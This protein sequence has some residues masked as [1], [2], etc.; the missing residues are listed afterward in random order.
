MISFSSI[1]LITIRELA[2]KN[3][4]ISGFKLPEEGNQIKRLSFSNC[5]FDTDNY[6]K[7]ASI[8]SHYEYLKFEFIEKKYLEKINLLDA[9]T[10]CFRNCELSKEMFSKLNSGVKYLDL[11]TIKL[12]QEDIEYIK[13]NNPSLSVLTN[14][15]MPNNFKINPPFKQIEIPTQTQT[16]NGSE[17]KALVYKN[18][19][20]NVPKDAFL[21]SSGEPYTGNVK[22]EVVEYFTPE[23]ILFSGIPMTYNEGDENFIF[24][25]GGMIDVKGL[26]ESGEP[27]KLAKPIN[28][29]INSSSANT[30]MNLY[31]LNKKG[32]W[33]FKEKDTIIEAFKLNKKKLDSV[34]SQDFK[35]I[36][37]EN[38]VFR[39]PRVLPKIEKIKDS[40][41]FKIKFDELPTTNR[42]I[43]GN[44][45]IYVPYDIDDVTF[46]SKSRL[47]YYGDSAKYYSKLIKSIRK[48]CKKD[49]KKLKNKLTNDYS[50]N[51]PEYIRNIKLE[52]DLEKDVFMLSFTFKDDTIKLPM[53]IDGNR[54][55]IKSELRYNKRLYAKYKKA[56]KKRERGKKKALS[57]VGRL[58]AYKA[59]RLKAIELEREEKRRILR[60]DNDSLMMRPVEPSSIIRVF[61]IDGFGLFNCDAMAR[62]IS[63]E[64]VGSRFICEEKIIDK[65][66]K[67]V[68]VLDHEL[69]GV[70][71]FSDSNKAFYDKASRSTIIIFFSQ[72]LIGIYFSWKNHDNPKGLELNM[73]DVSG[74]SNEQ[75]INLVRNQ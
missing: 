14:E 31:R 28:V 15:N 66:V 44:R 35:R 30:D 8:R 34:A 75:L 7:T 67:K 3:C 16:M 72:T 60:D 5:Q 64:K 58:I 49:Y 25:S 68:I 23:D 50:L 41:G 11:R 4:F 37:S 24:S 6:T 47:V 39:T 29:V 46:L 26:S 43:N 21:T 56:I 59:K 70:I 27:L 52:P 54:G 73:F 32:V 48:K 55:N 12:N 20:L 42:F 65:K 9:D 71:Q 10:L 19:V 1:N 53:I 36:I 51:G 62:M 22:M 69:N 17:A 18:T 63:P 40:D 45:F 13:R 33:E 74:M 2:L 61:S 38:V 57:R